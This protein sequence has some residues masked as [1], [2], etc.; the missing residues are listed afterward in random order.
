MRSDWSETAGSW[1][2]RPCSVVVGPQMWTACFG[3][4]PPS[5]YSW[6]GGERLWLQ[7]WTGAQHGWLLQGH[8]VEWNVHYLWQSLNSLIEKGTL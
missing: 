7:A 8:R 6:E 5:I 3:S 1:V 2:N 4:C